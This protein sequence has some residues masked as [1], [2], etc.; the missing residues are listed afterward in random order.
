MLVYI[1]ASAKWLLFRS[2]G[3]NATHLSAC[4]CVSPMLKLIRRGN[5]LGLVRTLIA[6]PSALMEQ[7]SEAISDQVTDLSVDN[8]FY[9][10]AK[11][12]L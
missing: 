3:F 11:A 7:R 10:T 6:T 5:V 12:Q 4:L 1:L 9:H 8:C 2:L